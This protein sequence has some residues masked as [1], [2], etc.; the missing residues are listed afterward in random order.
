V[1]VDRLTPED[2]NA[3]LRSFKF[4]SAGTK[5]RTLTRLKA[6]LNLA[7]RERNCSAACAAEWQSVAPLVNAAKRREVYLDPEQRRA[8]LDRTQGAFRD[9]VEACALTGARPGELMTA[10]RE[11]FDARQGTVR[12]YWRKGAK[13]E[14]KTRTIKL[15]PRALVLFRKLAQSKLPK[16]HLFV[17]DD[18]P[19]PRVKSKP[20]P[21]GPRAWLKSDYDEL[22]IE[23]AQLAS[24][25]RACREDHQYEPIS[26]EVVLYSF[27]HSWITQSLMENVPPQA[28]ASYT[29]TSLQML[30]RHYAQYIEGQVHEQIA[31]VQML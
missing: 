27:R 29:G 13:G 12:L 25:A 3:W 4:K 10:L 5:N 1:Q 6:A 7:V 8:L 22:L 24:S 11:Q 28:V 16:A 23:A 2:L 30:Q 15:A 14:L 19:T 21:Q 17:R 18:V 20:I 26:P 9:F 31:R